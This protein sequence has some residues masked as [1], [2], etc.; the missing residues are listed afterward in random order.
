M[1]Y[2]NIVEYLNSYAILLDRL[3]RLHWR[4][5][6]EV[7]FPDWDLVVFLIQVTF[8]DQSEGCSRNDF[9]LP[10]NISVCLL[11]VVRLYGLL[12]PDSGQSSISWPSSSLWLSSGPCLRPAQLP[13]SICTAI[14]IQSLPSSRHRHTHTHTPASLQCQDV[15]CPTCPQCGCPCMQHS[16]ATVSV[17]AD[18]RLALAS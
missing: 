12:C 1:R 7:F 17:L 2:K 14:N 8:A 15:Y 9:Q 6:R 3:Q 10:C 18:S 5:K 16:A 13:F 4:T 11:L